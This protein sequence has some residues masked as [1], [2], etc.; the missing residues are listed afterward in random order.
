M[1]AR[2][3]AV[4]FKAERKDLTSVKG[5]LLDQLFM[6]IELG[7]LEGYLAE[8]SSCLPFSDQVV[9]SLVHAI[10]EQYQPGC[11]SSKAMH[12]LVIQELS[13]GII[14]S[15]IRIVTK[16]P[17]LVGQVFRVIRTILKL[18]IATGWHFK[19]LFVL[20]CLLVRSERELWGE[21]SEGPWLRIKTYKILRGAGYFA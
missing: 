15:S 19:I 16:L 9:P 3:S 17:T 6:M 5:P 10:L 1:T 7:F 11:L 21:V 2:R 14:P 20:A 12:S 18:T 4:A 8:P 13:E